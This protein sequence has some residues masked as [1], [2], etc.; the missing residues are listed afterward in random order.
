MI[1]AEKLEKRFGELCAVDGISF[2]IT[3]GETFGPSMTAWP[4]WKRN[5]TGWKP[6]KGD[7]P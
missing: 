1:Q 3:K 2:E 5:M 6:W 7:P 4:N